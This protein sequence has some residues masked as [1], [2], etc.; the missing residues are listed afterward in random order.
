[1]VGPNSDEKSGA[2][3]AFDRKIAENAKRLVSDADL[4]LQ[5]GRFASAFALAVL[6]LEESGK[7]LLRIW[8]TDSD[9]ERDRKR[10]GQHKVKQ[11][12]IGVLYLAKTAVE[13]HLAFLD[14]HSFEVKNKSDVMPE[15]LKHA[16]E[17][18]S[19]IREKAVEHVAKSMLESEARKFLEYS[20]VGVI[21]KTKQAAFYVDEWPDPNISPFGF[22]R[23]DAKQMVEHAKQAIELMDHPFFPV[24]AKAIYRTRLERKAGTKA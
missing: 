10:Y 21:D 23:D 11:A 12:V 2:E 1:M 20:L 17:M 15:A 24:V 5:H 14:Q 4:L 22:E 7:L 8:S 9:I 3:S 13:S 6:S 18:Y 16:E 19:A